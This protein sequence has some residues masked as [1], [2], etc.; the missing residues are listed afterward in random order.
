M[1]GHIHNYRH[2]VALVA[3]LI[4]VDIV[5]AI[6]AL[7]L[8]L[9]SGKAQNGMIGIAEYCNPDNETVIYVA[10]VRLQEDEAERAGYRAL[11]DAVAMVTF[12]PVTYTSSL[13]VA[14]YAT[15]TPCTP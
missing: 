4:I 9:A 5:L 10:L 6:A 14:V 11:S 12:E 13:S 3:G 2:R 7:S 15:R 1:L 8:A